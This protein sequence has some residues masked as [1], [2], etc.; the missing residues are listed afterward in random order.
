MAVTAPRS[1]ARHETAEAG[2]EERRRFE[3]A[4]ARIRARAAHLDEQEV[5]D[6]ID[7]E[8]EAYRAGRP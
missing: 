2:D 3:R 8:L 6:L 4:V 1:V 7:E 5:H